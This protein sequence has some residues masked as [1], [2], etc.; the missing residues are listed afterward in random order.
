MEAKDKR[1]KR[2][3]R[4]VLLSSFGRNMFFQ[5]FHVRIQSEEQKCREHFA[6]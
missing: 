5:S 6:V 1:A 4:L 3:M 2:G